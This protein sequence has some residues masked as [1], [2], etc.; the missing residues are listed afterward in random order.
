LRDIAEL[1]RQHGWRLAQ[2]DVEQGLRIGQQAAQPQNGPD[3]LAAI[4]ALPALASKDGAGLLVLQ[5]F[6]RFLQSAEIV[7]AL[8]RQIVAGKQT[9]TFVVVLSPVVQIPVELEK[10]FV[11]IEHDLPGRDQLEEIARGI[12]V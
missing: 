3:P 11:V 7:Q 12:A 10:L 9:R 2:W 6:H 5:N 8:L 4:R 1:C